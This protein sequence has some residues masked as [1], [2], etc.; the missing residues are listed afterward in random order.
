MNRFLL[1]LIMLPAALWHGLGADVVQLKAILDTK[2][3]LDDRKPLPIGRQQKQKK[4]KFGSL[5]NAVMFL[6]MGVLYMMPIITVNDRIAS[7]TIYFSMLTA[8]IT[9]MLIT[10]FSNVLFDSR[11]KYILFPRPINDRTLVLARLLH[12]VIYLVRVVFPLALPGWVALG[13]MD[14]WK[15]ATLFTIPLLLLV[16]L[17]LFLVNCIYLL[18]LRLAK[19]E[20]FKDVINYFQVFTSVIFFASVYL[21]PR[22]FD[23][24]NPTDF[25]ILKYAW[26]RFTPS[27]W[28]ASCWSWI[29]Y[30][31]AISGSAVYSGLAVVVPVACMFILVKYLTPSF[32]S[33][34]AGIDS[35]DT[36]GY[37]PVQNGKRPGG[38]YK[39]LAYAFNV[40]DEARAGFIIAW[41]Q[42]SR[43]RSFRMRVYPSF[44]FI[45]IYFYYTLTLG[46]ES[47]SEVMSKLPDTSKHL[48]LLYFS[49]FVMVSALSY[50]TMS[51][52]YK[53]AWVYHATPVMVPGRIMIGAFKA[54]WV[55]FFLPFYILLAAFVL[56]IWGLPAILDVLLAVIN[57][58]MFI[59]A[60]ARINMRHLPFS[61]IEQTK[62]S[63]GR[64]LKS[65]GA[66]FIL[67]P[68][69]AGHYFCVHLLWL[70]LLFI[71][72]SSVL[73]W[74]IWTSYANT[75]WA[76]LVRS[77]N[78]Q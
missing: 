75:T 51:D 60:I 23:R 2:L 33:K 28:L 5:I 46:G 77:E 66:M 67:G 59:C 40:S 58:T 21:F 54:M 69:G 63:G 78:E 41:L 16:F 22:L 38:L 73:L 6:F 32:A 74:L 9:F 50:I 43:S 72:L 53:A 20:K 10:D 42:T 37:K 52:Q 19:P 3:K 14:G 27:Y 15:S 57:V 36:G 26:V 34:I 31:V 70:K 71:A 29:G 39:K 8:I 1:F 11:D 7:L 45:P 76:S 17:A 49:S 18:I 64:I 65:M 30:P 24:K 25:N 35:A 12:V 55:K 62:Q 56:Y 68:L 13:Y 44:A 48:F 61:I 47:F 4:I